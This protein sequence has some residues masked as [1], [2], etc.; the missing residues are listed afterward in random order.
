MNRNRTRIFVLISL[1]ASLAFAQ[2]SDTDWV[3][4]VQSPTNGNWGSTCTL[5]GNASYTLTLTQMPLQVGRAPLTIQGSGSSSMLMRPAY[6]AA[7]AGGSP[8]IIPSAAPAMIVV[9]S[10]VALVG[11][12]PYTI[13]FQNIMIDGNRANQCSA[14]F[15][16]IA[17][18]VSPT[19]NPSLGN[20]SLEGQ[21]KNSSGNYVIVTNA[22][23][24]FAAGFQDIIID[25]TTQAVPVVF[26]G[27]TMFDAPGY[28]ILIE[29]GASGG[30]NTVTIESST[31]GVET[32]TYANHGCAY[33]SCIIT[34]ESS[35]G[36]LPYNP[37][38]EDST[39]FGA[40]GGAIAINYATYPEIES[41][42]FFDNMREFP[43][44]P[45]AGGEGVYVQ[46][47]STGDSTQAFI[48]NN[49]LNGNY[50]DNTECAGGNSS[51][52]AGGS[53][54]LEIQGAD[55]M[56]A[57]N[58][59]E[60]HYG[61]GISLDGVVC[62]ELLSNT[63]THDGGD[64]LYSHYGIVIKADSPLPES[65]NILLTDNYVY[66]NSVPGLFVWTGGDGVAN[67]DYSANTGNSSYFYDNTGGNVASGSAASQAW[68]PSDCT[69]IP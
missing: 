56:I 3:N 58:Y 36:Q 2:S 31:F 41:N 33:L 18:Y 24:Q 57:N 8:P 20:P 35:S 23:G 51:K 45:S 32:G 34:F 15:G 66:N 55:H 62:A 19:N 1:S 13:T 47:N 6:N 25:Y 50:E 54:G 5:P 67:I 29:R 44:C 48:Y 53:S 65:Q 39:F 30:N 16:C 43:W 17:E 59:L 46:Y 9:P 37:V 61:D 63:V 14:S 27:V 26:S 68:V 60:N 22:L 40:G 12:G 11:S 49:T 4:C 10:S 52:Y 28:G 42:T 21:V 64:T 7:S 69:L 38:I